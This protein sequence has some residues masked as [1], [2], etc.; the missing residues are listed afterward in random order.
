MCVGACVRWFSRT[1]KCVT[2]LITEA[3]YVALADTTKE[4][5]FLRYVLSFISPGLGSACITVYG[6][7]GTATVFGKLSGVI[8]A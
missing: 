4:V 6:D 2:L 1:Q 3:E 8:L 7:F 5:V